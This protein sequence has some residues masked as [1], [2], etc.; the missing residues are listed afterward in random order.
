MT[1]LYG[2]IHH[3]LLEKTTEGNKRGLDKALRLHEEGCS[4]K[5]LFLLL[6]FKR[7]HHILE[8]DQ[9]FSR[10][11]EENRESTELNLL[12]LHTH[13]PDLMEYLQTGKTSG[14]RRQLAQLSQLQIPGSQLRE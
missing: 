13:I 4:T 1:L 8:I 14:I 10:A 9:N 12:Q 2:D 5:K 3:C 6:L 7:V 11:G